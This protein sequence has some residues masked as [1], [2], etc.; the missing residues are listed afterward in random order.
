MHVDSLPGLFRTRLCKFF[1]DIADTVLGIDF[2]KVA[3]SLSLIKPYFAMC[4][5][6]T[7]CNGWSTTARYHDGVSLSLVYLAV[8]I[9]LVRTAFRTTLIVLFFG[10]P[11]VQ[12]SEYLVARAFWRDLVFPIFARGPS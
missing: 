10:T 1:P 4:V 6:R 3:S 12:L 5:V 2:Q 7:F 11:L 9:A 8:H